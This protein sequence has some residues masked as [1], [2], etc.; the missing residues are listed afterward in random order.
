MKSK[1]L[2]WPLFALQ[3]YEKIGEF[4]ILAILYC[5]TVEE[6]CEMSLF[7]NVKQIKS[8][9]KNK[10]FNVYKSSIQPVYWI[11]SAVHI[12]ENVCDIYERETQMEKMFLEKPTFSTER[13]MSPGNLWSIRTKVYLC[14]I[15]WD[16]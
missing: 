11:E 4:Y 7:V 13:N 3:A 15:C 14:D 6:L 8:D 12:F 5:L 2:T 9:G 16:I 10:T 1:F